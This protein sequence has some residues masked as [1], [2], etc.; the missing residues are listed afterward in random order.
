MEMIPIK[1]HPPNTQKQK[2]NPI[3]AATVLK[4]LV[5]RKAQIQA[6]AIERD[7]HPPIY[8]EIQKIIY[9]N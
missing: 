3:D 8:L 7:E 6:S 4:F 1:P 9:T 5:T 2:E